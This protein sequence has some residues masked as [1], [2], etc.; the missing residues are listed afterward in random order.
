MQNEVFTY[1]GCLQLNV[2]F[3]AGLHCDCER[4]GF[5]ARDQVEGAFFWDGAEALGGVGGYG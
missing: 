1:S 3:V 2:D 4:D 5:E